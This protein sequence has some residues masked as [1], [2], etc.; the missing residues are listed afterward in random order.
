MTAKGASKS[1]QLSTESK[2]C[3]VFG[4]HHIAQ[5]YLPKLFRD[6][7]I[8]HKAKILDVGCG[9]GIMVKALRELGYDAYGLE[10]GGRFN[11]IEPDIKQFIHNCYADEFAQNISDTFDVIMSFGV[12]E[13]VGTIDGHACLSPDFPDYRL[14]FIEDQVKLLK[15]GGF[16]IVMGPNRMFPFDFQ[17]GSH[18]YG[19]LSVVKSRLAFL[20]IIQ[21]LTIPWHNK[22]YLASWDDLL[23]ISKK[24]SSKLDIKFC[25][26]CPKQDNLLGL[27]SIQS[28]QHLSSLFRFYIKLVDKLPKQL[29]KVL[30]THTLF[31]L[32]RSYNDH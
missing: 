13:H 20:K 1:F 18:D 23:S 24:L 4:G 17:H 15:P 28:K 19:F 3:E 31:V 14:Q 7:G 10:P 21:K 6:L 11:G 12:I 2:F 9:I 30:Y 29:R 32:Q 5:V 25:Y 22:N 27:S 8:D 16:L 26:F